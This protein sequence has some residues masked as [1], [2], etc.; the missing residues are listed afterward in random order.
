MIELLDITDIVSL[1]IGAFGLGYVT[2]WL[3][4]VFRRVAWGTT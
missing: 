1:I 4:Y 2:S 3:V